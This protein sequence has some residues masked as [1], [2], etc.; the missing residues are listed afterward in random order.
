MSKTRK[1]PKISAVLD[2]NDIIAKLLQRV[3]EDLGL[4]VVIFNEP[5]KFFE[6]IAS[7]KP[8]VAFIDFTLPGVSGTAVIKRLR[9]EF[10]PNLKIIAISGYG[11]DLGEEMI[12]AGA[13]IF[14][15]KPFSRNE[16]IMAVS[17]LLNNS[18]TF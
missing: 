13:D 15:A 3:L 8:H 18:F 6:E 17:K 7:V 9:A 1:R 2:D 12:K 14:L 10:D 5:K 16:V 11:D 4:V